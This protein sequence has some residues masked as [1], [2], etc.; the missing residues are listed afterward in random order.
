MEQEEQPE[1]PRDPVNFPPLREP[2]TEKRRSTLRPR[3]FGQATAAE[4]D[5]TSFSNSA[6]HAAQRNS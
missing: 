4:A 6:A 3:H 5:V 2:N 1:P